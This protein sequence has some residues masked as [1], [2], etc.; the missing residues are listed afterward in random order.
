VLTDSLFP[1][2]QQWRRNVKQLEVKVN[3]WCRT[4]AEDD[5]SVLAGWY[6]CRRSQRYSGLP[7]CIGLKDRVARLKMTR[8]LTG[9]QCNLCRRSV[10]LADITACRTTR[11]RLF[12]SHC[13]RSTFFTSPKQEAVTAV[14]P[15]SNDWSCSGLG[16][17]K[18]QERPDVVQSPSVVSIVPENVGDVL[19]EWQLHLVWYW[20][21]RESLKQTLT[22]ATSIMKIFPDHCL[23][24]MTLNHL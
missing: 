21:T 7:N 20:A 8:C 16:C 13:C 2:E 19:V 1:L 11:A 22:P 23:I 12:L 17:F 3:G 15:S 18:G 14:E 24:P 4:W 9:S 5:W 10:E 6:S